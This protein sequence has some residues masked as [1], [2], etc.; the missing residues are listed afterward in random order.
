[1]RVRFT[2]LVIGATLLFSVPSVFAQGT[3][4]TLKIGSL[5]TG[6]D[7]TQSLSERFNVRAGFDFMGLGYADE[8][9]GT[10]P[11][12]YDLD[13]KMLSFALL[14]EYYPFNFGMRLAGGFV[15]DGMKIEGT[16][17]AVDDYEFDGQV[18]TTE[19][20]G[21]FSILTEPSS[22]FSPY[23]G[24]GFGNPVIPDK[25]VGMTFDIGFMYMGSP[26][27]TLTAD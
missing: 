18:F 12:A 24:I 10:V 25:K 20:I 2:A 8:T 23:L 6:L 9:K 1:M 14:A 7:V 26:D 21:E 16:G 27:V 5:G 22:K 17:R 3:A 15:Y 19:E 11:V 4:L 13:L